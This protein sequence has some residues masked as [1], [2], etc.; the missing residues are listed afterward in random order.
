MK[1]KILTTSLVL[2]FVGLAVFGFLLMH[3]SL[4]SYAGLCVAA[5][6]G[7]AVCPDG[8]LTAANFHMNAFRSFSSVLPAVLV[9]LLLLIVPLIASKPG[10]GLGERKTDLH[11]AFWIAAIKTASF[12]ALAAPLG[13]WLALRERE[14]AASAI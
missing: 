7:A 3:G 6:D 1:S 5:L 2:S 14:A 8:G 12:F 13:K 4:N 11:S 9:M 10:M